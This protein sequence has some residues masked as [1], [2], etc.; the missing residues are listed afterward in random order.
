METSPIVSDEI[1]NYLKS[2]SIESNLNEIVNKILRAFP[3]DPYSFMIEN[4]KS[5]CNESVVINSIS[6]T[7]TFTS[8]LKIIPAISIKIT[9]KGNTSKADCDVSISN[10]ALQADDL[11]D[12]VNSKFAEITKYISDDLNCADLSTF[13][14]ILDS[15]F[16]NYEKNQLESQGNNTNLF[17]N[18]QLAKNIFNSISISAYLAFAKAKSLSLLSLMRE[19]IE[20]YFFETKKDKEQR[21]EIIDQNLTTSRTNLAYG[22]LNNQTNN[23]NSY[24][25][26][27]K[28]NS[29]TNLS[30]AF[31]SPNLGIQIFKCGKGVSKVKYEKFFLILDL[32]ECPSCIML[33]NCIKAIQTITKKVLTAGKLGENG[34]RI[35]PEGSHFSPYDTINDTVK[36]LEEMIKEVK[37]DTSLNLIKISIG[38][39]CQA[40]NYFNEQTK[41]Y[42]MDGI[43]NPLESS[44]LIDY[45][46]QYFNDHPMITY[47]EDPIAD[48]DISGWKELIKRAEEKNSLLKISC[49]NL[50]CNKLNNLKHHL[51]PIKYEEVVK[52]LNQKNQGSNSKEL[53]EKKMEEINNSKILPTYSALKYNEFSSLSQLIDAI[54]TIK[55]KKFACMTLWDSALEYNNQGLVDLSFAA[56]S[57]LIIMSGLNSKQER[58]NMFINFFKNFIDSS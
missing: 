17:T 41:K 44:K 2:T 20:K 30:K 40:N 57:E 7:K 58:F 35:N 38:I 15:H 28:K 11:Y 6:L 26:T 34:F 13:D 9:Y 8:D 4:I 32:S 16:N 47:I 5:Y 33:V 52:I 22:S 27:N 21:K 19:S 50:I 24:R 42:D 29:K 45:Y 37:K 1:K 10:S 46:L 55:N 31:K 53:P 49:K 23:P 3:D 14:G 51:I 43:K 36:C 48:S 39:D 56:K 54:K 18:I 12:K 25:D